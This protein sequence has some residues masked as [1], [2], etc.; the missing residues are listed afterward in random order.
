M[1]T[2]FK[3]MSLEEQN[4]VVQSVHTKNNAILLQNLIQ[5]KTQGKSQD[6]Q[7]LDH[8]KISSSNK[9][10][11]KGASLISY[12]EKLLPVI[13][14]KCES[15]NR[16]F[17]QK[18][19]LLWVKTSQQNLQTELESLY[20]YGQVLRMNAN[21]N[22]NDKKDALTFNAMTKVITDLS[23]F[24]RTHNTLKDITDIVLGKKIAVANFTHILDPHVENLNKISLKIA[25]IRNEF[26]NL[27]SYSRY[28][29]IVAPNG[30]RTVIA[31]ADDGRDKEKSHSEKKLSAPVVHMTFP[32]E[33][34]DTAIVPI[35][36]NPK[37]ALTASKKT[38]RTQIYT[39]EK[40]PESLAL[41]EIKKVI[42][43][44]PRISKKVLIAY[45]K[46]P[47]KN[48]KKKDDYKKTY[49]V[50][51]DLNQLYAQDIQKE[52]KCWDYPLV[53]AFSSGIFATYFQG[54]EINHPLAS[55]PYVILR[56][57]TTPSVPSAPKMKPHYCS[58]GICAGDKVFLSL[59]NK[60]PSSEKVVSAEVKAIDTACNLIVTA[61]IK[62]NVT[63]FLLPAKSPH[64]SKSYLLYDSIKPHEY[65]YFSPDQNSN[66]AGF[67]TIMYDEAQVISLST[68]PAA[69]DLELEKK[70]AKE[71]RLK[72]AADL[73]EAQAHNN[74]KK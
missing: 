6:Y 11:D 35:A 65:A 3:D 18:E 12:K 30:N 72:K 29:T 32:S 36:P 45:K 73:K 50:L 19:T 64:I 15:G 55:V 51:S 2:D 48:P 1:A 62:E 52:N 43:S 68:T 39:K 7:T 49:K 47:R 57:I 25:N 67:L 27:P 63:H 26:M 8:F 66:E 33:S 16:Y 10:K 13:K 53:P 21:D 70:L 74:S 69:D 20:L 23:S 17:C 61:T 22:D 46:A 54:K 60:N 38:T 28:K 9:N 42:K 31:K 71:M 24:M 34:L 5:E 44:E 59:D 56:H 41:K 40:E 14:K 37:T 4:K 58:Q